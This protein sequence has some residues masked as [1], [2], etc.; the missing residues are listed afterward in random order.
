MA[1]G[2]VRKSF[3]LDTN[4]ILHDSSCLTQ[5]K[6]HAI[7]IPISVLEELDHFKKGSQS[8]NYHAREFLRSLDGL[9]SDAIFDRGV[10]IGPDH[11]TVRVQLE[12]HFHPD[13]E[14]N[15]SRAKPDHLILNCAYTLAKQEEPRRRVILVS[16][17]VNMRLKAKAVG[18]LS[19][20]YT[21]DHVKD[22]SALYTGKRAV[23]NLDS[24]LIDCLYAGPGF[25]AAR[26]D[27][28]SPLVANENLI[29]RNHQ[30][31][32]L[33]RFHAQDGFVR[34]VNKHQVFGISPRNAEQTFALGVLCD[35]GIPLVSLTGTAGTGKTLLALAAALDQRKHYRQIFLARPIV[36]LSNK[37]MG[38]L[39]GEVKAKLDPYMQPIY[40]NLGVIMNHGTDGDS[41]SPTQQI[42]QMLDDEKLTVSALSYIRGR[43][44][45][46]I[47]FI[48]DEA[49]NLTPHEIKTIIT[50]AGEGTK[51][52]FTGDI[53]Q[54][55]HPYLDAQS[56]G[57]SYLIEKMQGQCLYAHVNL[58]KGERSELAHLAS[59]LL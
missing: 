22:V 44:L 59:N 33:A 55:D 6:H 34:R 57:L 47:F 32:A 9:S 49:Q 29:L 48:V 12:Q 53:F 38:F 27:L 40:D 46:R 26:L 3:V 37:D 1:R 58:E 21:S 45:N 25:E 31:S 54:I 5:F 43:S 28:D 50:R 20:D 51:I 24:A 42:Q 56:N 7:V 11:G 41:R 15:F 4:V 13:L 52:V 35:P 10:P 23:E 14:L 39:P 18:L 19:E 2:E 36:P 16:K 30:K 8:L 17:D